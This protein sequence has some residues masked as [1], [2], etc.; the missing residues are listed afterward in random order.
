MSLFQMSVAGGVLILFIVVIRALAIHR[1]PKTTF[2]ALWMIAALRLLLPLSIPMPFKIHIDLDVFSDVVQKLP[3]GNIGFPIPGESRHAYDTGAVVSSPAA[4][5]I[6]IFV[7]L[8]LVGVLLLA[9][10][11]SISYLRSMRKF[12]MSVPDNTPYIREWLN[13]HQ[14]VRPIEVRSSDLISSPL[15]YGILHPVIL[16]PKKLDRNDQAALQ[17]VLTHEYVHIRRFDAITKILFAAVLCIHWFNPL[18]WGMYVLA[19]RDTELSCD[20]WV[21]RMTG[22]K[23]RSSYALMLIKMEERRNG[24]SALWNHFGKNA[25]SERIEAIMKFKKTSIWA[26][27]LALALIAGATTAFAA[28]RTDDNMELMG[29]G[30]STAEVGD[31][32]AVEIGNTTLVQRVGEEGN[33][34]DN[35]VTNIE[36]MAHMDV[37]GTTQNAQ[38]MDITLVSVSHDDESKFTP[39]EWAEILKQIEQGTVHWED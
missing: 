23:N 30:F 4:E 11:F 13:A 19:N 9:L 38:S 16:L 29:L 37:N 28:A 25:I 17:Y 22:V 21:I 34:A 2:L 10:Y 15:T 20:A 6:S 3:S 35:R 26:C 1:L 18:V 5:R 31:M 12:R 32:E 7:I 24:M 39:E 33:Q 27:I 36:D 8:W 14:I